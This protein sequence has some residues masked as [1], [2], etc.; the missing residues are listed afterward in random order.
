MLSQRFTRACGQPVVSAQREAVLEPLVFAPLSKQSSV[1]PVFRFRLFL[2]SA[3]T[4]EWRFSFFV[5]DRLGVFR[6]SDAESILG[7][8]HLGELC[9]EKAYQ[10]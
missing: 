3:R 1:D 2:P 9:A 6:R 8:V 10:G 5:R 4:C 7:R